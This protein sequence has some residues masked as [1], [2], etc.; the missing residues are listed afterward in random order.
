MVRQADCPQSFNE[1][2]FLKHRCTF[3]HDSWDRV[4]A[5]THMDAEFVPKATLSTQGSWTCQS[6]AMSLG[7]K[8]LDSF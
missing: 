6:D 8:G 7:K 5:R 4:G 2:A 1:V 3:S